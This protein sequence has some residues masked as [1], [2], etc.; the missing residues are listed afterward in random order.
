MSCHSSKEKIV[1]KSRFI[2]PLSVSRQGFEGRPKDP[3]GCLNII[4]A[5]KTPLWNARLGQQSHTALSDMKQARLIEAIRI[6]ILEFTG[7]NAK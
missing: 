7:M 3:R 2:R 1:H 5:L 6:P 4:Q